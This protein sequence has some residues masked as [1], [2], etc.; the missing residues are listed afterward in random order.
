MI[1]KE[2]ENE[3]LEQTFG[4]YDEEISQS[5]PTEEVATKKPNNQNKILVAGMGG[6]IV[7]FLIWKF[8]F[9]SNVVTGANPPL[10]NA[11][12]T[13]PAVVANVIPT[14][15]AQVVNTSNINPNNMAISQNSNPNNAVNPSDQNGT[16]NNGKVVNDFLNTNA[17]N[18]NTAAS[19]AA[20]SVAPP[21]T[22]LSSASTTAVNTAQTQPNEMNKDS[23]MA[24]LEQIKNLID[25]QNNTLDNISQR[26][27]GLEKK[28]DENKDLVSKVSS[29]EE[30]LKKLEGKTR[31]KVASSVDVKNVVESDEKETTK[32]KHK[33]HH[34]A[35]EKM[36]S[37]SETENSTSDLLFVKPSLVA[38]VPSQKVVPPEST[39]VLHSIVSNRF[40]IKNADGSHSTYTVGDRLP[41]GDIV[42]TIDEDKSLVLT[43]GATIK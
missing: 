37:K 42:K 21:T 9:A 39:Y 36:M 40:W 10:N 26:V 4:S 14:T 20:T 43:S 15:T 41:N 1:E 17:N 6:A 34:T 11:N 19:T 28:S 2:K 8:M 22:N 7:L 35:K 18:T 33:V 12:V 30:R 23:Q 5:K 25:K 3:M 32:V 24:V 27:D 38:K 16:V 29:I 31:V 13:N